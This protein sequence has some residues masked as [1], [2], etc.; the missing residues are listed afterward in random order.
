MNCFID[1]EDKLSDVEKQIFDLMQSNGEIEISSISDVMMQ[2]K[3]EVNKIKI[4]LYC[5]VLFVAVFGV[6]NM[7]NT[8][9]TNII[10]RQ[11]EFAILQAI[12]LTN[13][14]FVKILQTECLYYIVETAIITLTCGTFAGFILC[15]LGTCYVCGYLLFSVSIREGTLEQT[16]AFGPEIV[17]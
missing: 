6:I 12:G 1:V 9:M 13:K 10:S 7:I 8:L 5:L 15:P 14:Q 3:S 11:Q 2:L 4:P 17:H 16:D